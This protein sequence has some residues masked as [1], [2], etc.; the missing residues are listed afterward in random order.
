MLNFESLQTILLGIATDPYSAFGDPTIKPDPD[1]RYVPIQETW[2]LEGWSIQSYGDSQRF[3]MWVYPDHS[4]SNTKHFGLDVTRERGNEV[5]I[6]TLTFRVVAYNARTT[7]EYKFNFSEGMPPL[8]M[9]QGHGTN[10]TGEGVRFRPVPCIDLVVLDLI[11][12]M[13]PPRA[14]TYL[15]AGFSSTGG[16]KPCILCATQINVRDTLCSDCL[17]NRVGASYV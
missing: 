7:Y 13:M 8:E 4:G 16:T 11:E 17:S 12:K 15:P 5:V 9:R 10:V 3:A 2:Y 6:D 1:P 14:W